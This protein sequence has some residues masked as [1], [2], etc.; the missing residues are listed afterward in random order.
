MRFGFYGQFEDA[1]IDEAS[2]ANITDLDFQLWHI[3]ASVQ[4]GNTMAYYAFGQGEY[5]FN[6]LGG[7][8][9]D[10]DT[11][12][13]AILHNMSKRTKLYMGFSQVDCDARVFKADV[14]MPPPATVG[15]DSSA[16]GTVDSEAKLG[17]RGE[18]DKFSIGMKHTF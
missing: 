2:A 9:D 11:W 14:A 1:S 15:I 17:K 18:D 10:Y 16:C 7:K 13:L 12:T 5:D 6:G 4:M 8:S 3:A